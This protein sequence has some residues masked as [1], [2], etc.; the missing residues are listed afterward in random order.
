MQT[1]ETHAKSHTGRSL[2]RAYIAHT[3]YIYIL[4]HH[5]IYNMRDHAQFRCGVWGV[6]EVE[7]LDDRGQGHT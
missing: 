3:P 7:G 5:N 6:G 1:C 4:N 2:A